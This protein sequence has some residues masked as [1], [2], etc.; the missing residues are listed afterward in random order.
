[1]T[2]TLDCFGTLAKTNTENCIT[3]TQTKPRRIPRLSGLT[4]CQIASVVF[5]EITT[6]TSTTY[7]VVSSNVA[8]RV[9][10]SSMVKFMFDYSPLYVIDNCFRHRVSSY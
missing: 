1:M 3:Q 6:A 10:I 2:T 5:F 7:V 9:R 8:I 4:M